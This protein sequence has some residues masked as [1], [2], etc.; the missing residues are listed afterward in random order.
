MKNGEIM[1][2][3]RAAWIMVFIIG[4]LFWITFGFGVYFVFF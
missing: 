1:I 4:V 3:K 2:S